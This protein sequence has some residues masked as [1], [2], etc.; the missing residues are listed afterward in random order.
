[1]KGEKANRETEKQK[2]RKRGKG[3]LKEET[4]GRRKTEA[5]KFGKGK[6]QR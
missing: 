5:R 4:R 1:M 6:R 3:G 2:K